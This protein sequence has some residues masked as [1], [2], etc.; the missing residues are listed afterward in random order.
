MIRPATICLML[1]LLTASCAG[2]TP[3]GNAPGSAKGTANNNDMPIPPADAIEPPPELTGEGARLV[4]GVINTPLNGR[5]ILL[6]DPGE[7]LTR[8][9]H[10]VLDKLDLTDGP[11]AA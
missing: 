9:E 8:A 10:G 6:L 2:P 11:Q 1:G 7:L 5:M 3:V 4:N